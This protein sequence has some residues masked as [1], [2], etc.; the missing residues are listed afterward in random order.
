MMRR[1]RKIEQ[2]I[3]GQ[4]DDLSLFKDLL[5]DKEGRPNFP[6][7][8]VTS[9]RRNP[10]PR[11]QSATAGSVSQPPPAGADFADAFCNAGVARMEIQFHAKDA[12]VIIADR[13]SIEMSLERAMLLQL[14]SAPSSAANSANA[15]DDPLIPHKSLEQLQREIEQR[16]GVRLK[17]GSI[18]SSICRLRSKSLP[19]PG[20]I[21]MQLS[22]TGN[23]K[24]TAYRFVLRANGEL[25]VADDR[26]EGGPGAIGGATENDR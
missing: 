3:S 26:T 7:P 2:A 18:K 5:F 13:P 8:T 17:L 9:Q 12:T 10:D 20:L 19:Y 1:A 25:I 22:T 23:P 24:D 16:T 15:G 14:L 21:Q 6:L 11:N 4:N